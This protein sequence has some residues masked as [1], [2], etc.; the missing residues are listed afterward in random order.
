MQ[1]ILQNIGRE[2]GRYQRHIRWGVEKADVLWATLCPILSE[3]NGLQW[4][5]SWSDSEALVLPNDGKVLCIREDHGIESL[6]RFCKPDF[7]NGAEFTSL[8]FKKCNKLVQTDDQQPSCGFGFDWDQKL[9]VCYRV[10]Q[11][12][13][14]VEALAPCVSDWPEENDPLDFDGFKRLARM[15][16]RDVWLPV[17]RTSIYG[18]LLFNSRTPIYGI[19]NTIKI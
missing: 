5:P 4:P 19:R 12:G 15:I 9:N 1:H 3:P 11:P 14:W 16:E 18:P 17:R 7:I 10:T 6:G 2:V 8:D 13:S